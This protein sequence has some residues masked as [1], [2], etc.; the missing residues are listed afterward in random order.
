MIYLKV[1]LVHVH[2][3]GSGFRV[4]GT[5]KYAIPPILGFTCLNSASIQ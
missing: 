3:W 2:A 1:S 4:D 5:V